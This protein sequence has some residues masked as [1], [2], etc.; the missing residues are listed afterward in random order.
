MDSAVFH[1]FNNPSESVPL[2]TLIT[3]VFLLTEI[4]KVKSSRS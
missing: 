2:S 3:Y 1:L 4:V